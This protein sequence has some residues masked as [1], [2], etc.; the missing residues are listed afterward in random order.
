MQ[1]QY[2]PE[3]L[4][5]EPMIGLVDVIPQIS[6]A[7]PKAYLAGALWDSWWFDILAMHSSILPGIKMERSAIHACV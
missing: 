1:Y 4:A 2:L 6:T 5:A 3:S 7:G